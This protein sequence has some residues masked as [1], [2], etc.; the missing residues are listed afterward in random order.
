MRRFRNYE[1]DAQEHIHDEEG[2]D[3]A[4]GPANL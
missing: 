3:D 2:I 1:Y 4:T